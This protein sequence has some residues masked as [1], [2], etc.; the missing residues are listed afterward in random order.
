MHGVCPPDGGRC[1]LGQAQER[2]LPSV[3]SS[4]IAPIVSSIGVSGST[5]A[6][7]RGRCGRCPAAGAILRRPGGVSG[8]PL[9]ARLVGLSG[10]RTMPNLVAMTASSRRPARALP[11]S[12]SLVCGRTCRTCRRSR[13]RARAPGG[14]WRSTPRRWSDRRSRTSPCNRDPG[15]RPC[16]PCVPSA[17]VSMAIWL[18]SSCPPLPDQGDLRFRT[19]P[20]RGGPGYEVRACSIR[21]P[22]AA[23]SSRRKAYCSESMS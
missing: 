14:W 19:R 18:L 22:V 8:R 4:P 9:T 1:R 5:G 7:S 16:S 6:G 13:P 15:A 11:M 2:T 12:T 20:T 3:T 10:S 21:W 17:I 23:S